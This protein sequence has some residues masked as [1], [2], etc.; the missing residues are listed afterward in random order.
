MYGHWITQN[1]D[2]TAHDKIS[3]QTNQNR[4]KSEHLKIAI[5]S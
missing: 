4:N 1:S 3:N 2:K 5:K